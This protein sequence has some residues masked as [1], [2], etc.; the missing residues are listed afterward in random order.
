MYIIINK[1]QTYRGFT[2]D[3]YFDLNT[4]E[5]GTSCSIVTI[6]QNE[7]DQLMIDLQTKS[8][9]WD[10]NQFIE[11]IDIEYLKSKRTLDAITYYQTRERFIFNNDECWIAKDKLRDLFI[12]IQI[13]KQDVD[14]NGGNSCPE[15]INI[16]NMALGQINDI[17]TALGDEIVQKVRCYTR[18]IESILKGHIGAISLL[19]DT[20][21]II[22]YPVENDYPKFIYINS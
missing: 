10:G 18:K 6:G 1:D 2:E 14:M 5:N 16:E 21:D 20:N 17:S 3:E 7:F 13:Q 4:I 19:F 11:S 12:D 9:V 15:T 22:N 8:M